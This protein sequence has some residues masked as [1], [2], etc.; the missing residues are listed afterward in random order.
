MSSLP[1]HDPLQPEDL[2]APAE[3]GPAAPAAP[4]APAPME[5][6]PQEAPTSEAIWTSVPIPASSPVPAEPAHALDESSA[7]AP[8]VY[9]PWAPVP[10]ARPPA[11]IPNF[12]SLLMLVVL[13][14]LGLL[15]TGLLMGLAI[16]KH[17]F[18]ATTA[19]EAITKI[20][21]ILGSEAVLY[22]VTFGLALAIFPLFW[23]KNL[24]AGMQWNGATALRLRWR[25][26]SAAGV[27]FLLALLGDQFMKNPTNTPIEK[28]FRT[29]GAAWF[30]FAFG[31]TFAPFFEETLFRGFLLPALCTAYDWFAEKTTGVPER[32]LGPHGHPQWSFSAM[33]VASILTSIPFAWMHAEQTGYSLGPF[34][35]LVGVSLVL[36][37][38][39]LATRSLAS[40]V[41]VHASYNFLL[42]S[43]MLIGTGGFRHLDKM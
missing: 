38:V 39:R 14:S 26:V 23:H 18:G 31:V 15:A 13:A 25:L 19:Q 7:A 37:G 6:W 8:P 21:Y 32:P 35:L 10:P 11:R 20:Q 41:L 1:E 16:H 5:D 30:L 43:L 2:A 28:V 4:D 29:P 40:S 12:G 22:I 3:G 36:C 42:F 17:L 27:C 34:V 9:Q 24:F 33:V